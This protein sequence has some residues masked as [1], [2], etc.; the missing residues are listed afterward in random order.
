MQRQR[1]NRHVEIERAIE[2]GQ[3]TGN[4]E[5]NDE[6][7]DEDEI[8]RKQPG[9]RLHVT[10]VAVLDHG[11]MKLARQENDHAGR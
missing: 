6:K 9:R 4:G 8:E 2:K 3:A 5:R 11:D 10:F 7:I 1:Q